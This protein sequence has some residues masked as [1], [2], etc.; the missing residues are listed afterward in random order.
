MENKIQEKLIKNE[1]KKRLPIHKNPTTT[2][3]DE[4]K[5]QDNG[6]YCES[7]L[8]GLGRVSGPESESHDFRLVT[9]CS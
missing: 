7:E 6:K 5:E 9:S 4:K 3:R 8:K 2:F 1:K